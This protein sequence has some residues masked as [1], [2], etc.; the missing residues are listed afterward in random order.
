VHAAH[1]RLDEGNP[2][3][4]ADVAAVD[5]LA[6]A[7][8]LGQSAREEIQVERRVLVERDRL[9]EVAVVVVEPFFSAATPAS[10]SVLR[11]CR[12]QDAVK[13]LTA[14][15]RWSSDISAQSSAPISS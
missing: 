11:R 5:V 9:D 15:T 4:L 1:L 12:S 6:R 14:L 13:Y 2:V 3:G 10:R 8:R 7:E